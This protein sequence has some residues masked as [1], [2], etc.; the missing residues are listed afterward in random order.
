MNN[1]KKQPKNKG[2]ELCF[3]T[4]NNINTI[5]IIILCKKATCPSIIDISPYLLFSNT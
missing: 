1:N 3:E 4:K 2:R 5:G